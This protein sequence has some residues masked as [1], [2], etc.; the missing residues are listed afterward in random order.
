MS[1]PESTGNRCARARNH[2]G[3]GADFRSVVGCLGYQ[4]RNSKLQGAE[5][6]LDYVPGQNEI[7]AGVL[8]G[9]AVACS[10]DPRRTNGLVTGLSS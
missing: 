8:M 5:F 7:G 6:V 4:F 3:I 1:L 9:E 10:G 2:R